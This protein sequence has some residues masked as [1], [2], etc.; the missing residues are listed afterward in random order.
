MKA[1]LVPLASDASYRSL[2]ETDSPISDTEERPYRSVLQTALL[3]ARSLDGYIEGFP[4]GPEIP[5]LYGMEAPL[6][7]PAVLDQNW[8]REVVARSRQALYDFMRANGV[9]ERREEP[10][11][12][13]FGW[14]GDLRLPSRTRTRH[15]DRPKR[16]WP[17]TR[18]RNRALG[19]SRKLTTR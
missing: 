15:P 9:P 18:G 12:L 17:I 5:D 8:R 13:C 19:G 2:M 6:V 7:L 10:N 11:G 4:L 16:L 14:S 1:I 3:L